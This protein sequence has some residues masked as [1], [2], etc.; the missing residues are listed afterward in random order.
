MPID[1]AFL[2]ACHSRGARFATTRDPTALK[3]PAS[4]RL[5]SYRSRDVEPQLRLR[6]RLAA[7]PSLGKR[8][9]RDALAAG[10]PPDMAAPPRRPVGVIHDYTLRLKGLPARFERVTRWTPDPVLVFPGW[11]PVES[12]ERGSFAWTGHGE[13]AF[14]RLDAPPDDGDLGVRITLRAG[15]TGRHLRELVVELD[16]EAV[17][18]TQ[19]MS[20]LPAYV[21]TGWLPGRPGRRLS[22]SA[23]EPPVAR[24]AITTLRQ[25]THGGSASPCPRS[26]YSREAREGHWPAGARLACIGDQLPRRVGVP[27]PM[28]RR[29]RRWL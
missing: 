8:L 4:W 29:I 19:T 3:Y 13:R 1:Y 11:H 16:G 17:D 20:P 21:M 12:D 25:L 5:D 2:M 23:C 18:L 26:S 27:R 6:E 7:D 28:V 24:R 15:P 10:A 9:F 14:V 22:G